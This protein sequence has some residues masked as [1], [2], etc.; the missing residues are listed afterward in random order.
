MR[1]LVESHIKVFA[2]LS[3]RQYFATCERIA[4]GIG[5]ATDLAIDNVI[6]KALT[7]RDR[8]RDEVFSEIMYNTSNFSFEAKNRRSAA[9]IQP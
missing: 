1:C 2:L 3:R 7:A 8:S 6:C 4:E 5:S 9:L